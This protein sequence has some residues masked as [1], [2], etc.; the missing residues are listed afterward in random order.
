M[1][2]QHCVAKSRRHESA[3]NH[4]ERGRLFGYEEHG[5]ALAQALRDDVRDGLALP[6]AGRPDEDEV[7]TVRS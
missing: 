6:G 5:F 3:V 2:F 4:I 1:E 7:T